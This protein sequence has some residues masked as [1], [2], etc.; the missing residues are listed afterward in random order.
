M[1]RRAAGGQASYGA[2][3]R[4]QMQIFLVQLRYARLEGREIRR[5]LDHV[6]RKSETRVT[7]RLGP[8]R[9]LRLLVRHAVAPHQA[10]DLRRLGHVHDEHAVDVVPAAAFGQQRDDQDLVRAAGCA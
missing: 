10:L 3:A 5:V 4:R 9:R 1:T 7:T 6:V 2:C 8:E